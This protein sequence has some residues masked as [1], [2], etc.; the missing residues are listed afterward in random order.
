MR[1]KKQ[2][3][4]LF[5]FFF[6]ILSIYSQQTEREREREAKT[7]A[8]GESG[9]FREPDAGLDPRFPGS[10]PGLKAAL[11]H[12]ATGAA[13]QREFLKQKKA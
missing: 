3:E 5:F 1:G 12:W 9:L 8:E 11:N 7:Q 6:T 4:Y 2:S 10:H 13:Q